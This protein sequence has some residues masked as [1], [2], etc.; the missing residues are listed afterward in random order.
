MKT[1]QAVGFFALFFSL[2]ADVNA[3]SAIVFEKTENIYYRC[4]RTSVE[5]A[6]TCAM[7]YCKESSARICQLALAS[8]KNNQGW[9]A[10]VRYPGGAIPS[11]GEKSERDAVVTAM[12]KCMNS[13]P[14]VRCKNDMTFQ[15]T[16]LKKTPINTPQT[17]DVPQKPGNPAPVDTDK[18]PSSVSY[19]T[20]FVVNA[21]GYIVTNHH[22]IAGS[23]RCEFVPDRQSRGNATFIRADEENDLAILKADRVFGKFVTI[24]ASDPLKGSTVYAVGY[25][26]PNQLANQQN[27][28]EGRVSATAG[29]KNNRAHLQ[30]SAAIQP[31][32]SGGPLFDQAGIVVG[33][34]V[35]VLKS[36][37]MIQKDGIVAQNVNFAI[38]PS[39]L[40]QFLDTSAAQYTVATRNDNMTLLAETISA[41]AEA[42]VVKLECWK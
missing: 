17:R 4:T 1:W 38:Q 23:S 22:V 15:D 40:K 24:S 11:W 3:D 25:P 19:G 20:G 5:E 18:R 34:N 32:N 9:N 37:A 30:H 7:N 2:L 35:A 31:G 39:S 27:F 41:N 36:E 10:L 14:T 33:V 6:K 21:A 28:T 26:L 42:D 12:S 16:G 8:P 13:N 29:M